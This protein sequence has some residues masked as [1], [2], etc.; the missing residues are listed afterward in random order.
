MTTH[1]HTLVAPTRALRLPNPPLHLPSAAPGPPACALR[2]ECACACP[3]LQG[4]GPRPCNGAEVQSLHAGAVP[5]GR[6]CWWVRAAAGPPA[7]RSSGGCECCHACHAKT[8]LHAPPV[9]HTLSLSLCPP[10]LRAPRALLVAA[11]AW[12]NSL[13]WASVLQEA[14]GHD[15]AANQLVSQEEAQVGSCGPRALSGQPTFSTTPPCPLLSPP[16]HPAR[17]QERLD[18]FYT[19]VRRRMARRRPLARVRFSLSV[20]VTLSLQV[21]CPP[22]RPPAYPAPRPLPPG[23]FSHSPS[24]SK[25][26]AA[27]LPASRF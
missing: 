7:Q 20:D 21:S 23:L 2:M 1:H 16:P 13:F 15:P 11:G 3:R 17:C 4:A 10:P 27:C 24:H 18:A 22:A 25:S 8:L 14:N 6:A 19:S 5:A 26:N 12:D 9:I